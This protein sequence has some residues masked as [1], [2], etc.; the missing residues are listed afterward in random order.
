MAKHLKGTKQIVSLSLNS[1][2]MKRVENLA[3]SKGMSRS[4]LIEDLIENGIDQEEIAVAAFTN[5]VVRD[6]LMKSFARPEVIKALIK[7][8]G[9]EDPKQ[10]ELFNQGLQLLNNY[11]SEF[12]KNVPLDKVTERTMKKTIGAKKP[13]KKRRKKS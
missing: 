7:G 13:A 10:L 3:D 4:A 8:I 11:G 5:P 12:K 9:D 6:A 1:E 2:L